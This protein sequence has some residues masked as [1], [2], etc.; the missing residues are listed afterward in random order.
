MVKGKRL[1]WCAFAVL[2]G[3]IAFFCSFKEVC[4]PNILAETSS[5]GELYYFYGDF[6]GRY[7]KMFKN[8]DSLWRYTDYDTFAQ[9]EIESATAVNLHPGNYGDTIKAWRSPAKGRVN[10][11]G[12]VRLKNNANFTEGG[13]ADGIKISIEIR[14]YKEGRY[15]EAMPLE[16]RY[17]G[18]EIL[19][20]VPIEFLFTDIDVNAGDLIALSVNKNGNNDSDGNTCV[21]GVEFTKDESA[22]DAQLSEYLGCSAAPIRNYSDE[23]G[24]DGWFYAFGSVEKYSLMNWRYVYGA[25]QWTSHFPYQFIGQTIMHPSGKFDNL[26]IWIS[27]FDGKVAVSGAVSRSSTEGDGSLAGLYHNGNMLWQETCD[28]YGKKVYDIPEQEINVKKGDSIIFS[29][30]TGPKYD[31]VGDS[32][33]FITNIFCVQIEDQESALDRFS[34]LS[35]AEN[36]ADMS[37]TSIISEDIQNNC[38]TTGQTVGIIA[39]SVLTV[40]LAVFVTILA[41]NRKRKKQ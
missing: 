5:K 24:K 35:L 40:G 32:V 8:S 33:E 31:E 21:F 27:D 19:N 11:A 30:G 2:F 37:D 3:L 34:Y 4:F 13:N 15:L 1:I 14:Q 29:L 26:K 6:S 18:C 20:D 7:F 38:L 23:Q 36:E 39:G 10:I 12:S 17:S 16:P 28:Y 9:A 41:V 22:E 25:Y